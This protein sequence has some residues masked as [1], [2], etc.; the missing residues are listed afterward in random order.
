M[1]TRQK[2]T[3][4]AI[5]LLSLFKGKTES[6][7]AVEEM[8][9]DLSDKEFDEYMDALRSGKECLPYICPVGRNDLM[10]NMDDVFK[11][12][13]KINHNFFERL[14]I[15]DQATGE[16]SLTPQSYPVFMMPLKLLQQDLASKVSIPKDNRHVDDRTGQVTGASKGSGVSAPEL[17]MLASTGMLDPVIR[18]LYRARGGDEEGNRLLEQTVG[19]DQLPTL[20]AMGDSRTKAS[21]TA[22]IYWNAAMYQNNY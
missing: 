18:E 2:K 1:S 3:K 22:R 21:K 6:V 19:V 4:Y 17:K 10:V 16:T 13:E 8:L 12:A 7:V 14:W 11:V 9:N 5:E 20:S 15:T